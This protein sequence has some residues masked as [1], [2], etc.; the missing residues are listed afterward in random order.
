MAKH[1]TRPRHNARKKAKKRYQKAREDAQ[2]LGVLPT[3]PDE[4]IPTNR[5]RPKGSSW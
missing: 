5:P 4:H 1:P 2:L 3:V